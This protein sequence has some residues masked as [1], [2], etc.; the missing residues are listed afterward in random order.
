MATIKNTFKNQSSTQ[1][2][3]NVDENSIEE[4]NK[5]MANN[6][7]RRRAKLQ[8]NIR[9]GSSVAGGSEAQAAHLMLNPPFSAKAAAMQAVQINPSSQDHHVIM[10][11]MAEITRQVIQNLMNQYLMKRHLESTSPV[12]QN[13]TPTLSVAPSN[14]HQNPQNIIHIHPIKDHIPE[15]NIA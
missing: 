8:N 11:I 2:D 3:D 14:P 7:P 13:T 4:Q 15:L 5:L 9:A 10:D 1:N 6:S 12:I